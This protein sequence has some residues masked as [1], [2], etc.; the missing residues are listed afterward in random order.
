[1]KVEAPIID[2]PAI[3]KALD[4]ARCANGVARTTMMNLLV[5]TD[6]RKRDAWITERVEGIA[7]K[8]PARII[9]L[10]GATLGSATTACLPPA[11]EP[12]PHS[13]IVRFGI[14][15]CAPQV[16]RSLLDALCIPDVPEVLWWS[17]STIGVERLFEELA[18][19]ASPAILDSS[20]SSTG[21]EN[22][23]ELLDLTDALGSNPPVDLA[24]LR[25]HPVQEILATLFDNAVHRVHLGTIDR[26]RIEAGSLPEAAYLAAWLSR[27]LAAKFAGDALELV[28]HGEPRRINR[29]VL[30]S[31][32]ATYDISIDEKAHCANIM[33]LED[34][35]KATESLPFLPMST[36]ALVEKALLTQRSE[37]HFAAML[38]TVAQIC[39]QSTW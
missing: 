25:I 39:V 6:E 26:L 12:G 24:Y 27:A 13:E 17:G 7:R 5:Y 36:M 23:R 9:L 18:R 28:R 19:Y 38:E 37:P 35:R 29:C 15:D 14:V 10:D 34:N 8:Y 3:K 4:E 2:V 33:I 11:Q 1:M 31:D 16:V 20:G 22:L 30:R 21:Q 32:S